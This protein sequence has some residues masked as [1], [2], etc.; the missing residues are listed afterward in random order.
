VLTKP[1]SLQGGGDAMFPLENNWGREL[2]CGLDLFLPCCPVLSVGTVSLRDV[3][4]SRGQHKLEG[5]ISLEAQARDGRRD[6]VQPART[7]FCSD[8]RSPSVKERRWRW[9]GNTVTR[10]GSEGC[11]C[12][13]VS[14]VETSFLVSAK[15]RSPNPSLAQIYTAIRTAISKDCRLTTLGLLTSAVSALYEA[16]R[17]R[18]LESGWNVKIQGKRPRAQCKELDRLVA[19]HVRQPSRLVQRQETDCASC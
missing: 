8:V 7:Y 16:N 12:S 15:R 3:S 19:A 1:K 11:R 10:E 18:Y 17:T 14:R 2:C 13:H 5:F 4:R 9:C 6:S